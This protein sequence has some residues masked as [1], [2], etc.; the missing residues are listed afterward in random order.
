[1]TGKKVYYRKKTASLPKKKKVSVKKVEGIFNQYIK[2]ALNK[3]NLQEHGMHYLALF[4][5]LLFVFSLIQ[6]VFMYVRYSELKEVR[7]A[8][9]KELA[10]WENV[11][12]EHPGSPDV[13]YNAA[14]YAG[15]LGEREKAIKYLRLATV[16][17]PEFDE[18]RI[19]EEIIIAK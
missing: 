12:D 18:A 5:V 2:P 19:L 7:A 9:M 4:L 17:D 16:L 6:G 11:I 15:R 10:Y 13:Y 8:T 1:M 14:I 3:H